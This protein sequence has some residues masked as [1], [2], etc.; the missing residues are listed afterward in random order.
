MQCA[1]PLI[2]DFHFFFVVNVRAVHG[3]LNGCGALARSKG[4]MIKSRDDETTNSKSRTKL[5]SFALHFR[6]K[7][8]QFSVSAGIINVGAR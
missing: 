8:V 2:N 5:R 6:P 3:I 4:S 7:C 1:A